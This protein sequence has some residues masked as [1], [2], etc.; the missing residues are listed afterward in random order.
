MGKEF[1]HNEANNVNSQIAIF[2][3]VVPTYNE[4]KYIGALLERLLNFK[5]DNF[6]IEIIV[7][8]NG[9]TDNTLSIIKNYPCSVYVLLQVTIAEMRNHGAK[10]AHGKW[11]GFIDADCM[12]IENWAILAK[13]KLENN[14]EI[15]IVGSF[16]SK[17]SDA[18]WV[19]RLWYSMRQATVGKVNFLP[20]GN[21]AVCRSE[22]IGLGGFPNDMITGEDYALCQKYIHNGYSVYNDSSF[23][24]IH[25]GN[26]KKL[27]EIY[28]KEIWYGL[29]FQKAFKENLLSKVFWATAVFSL[30]CLLIVTLPAFMFFSEVFVLKFLFLVGLVFVGGVVGFYALVATIR[31]GKISYFFGYN[32]IFFSYFLGRSAAI[33]KLLKLTRSN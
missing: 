12:P 10:M 25:Y 30:G 9:S 4:E 21:M 23:K 20:A 19:E 17:T 31:S 28:K 7:I 5:L 29:S 33:F 1:F 32:L 11:I 13:N 18:T 2:S 26:V 24:T 22:F 6:A 3:V 27:V 14:P 8:D 15:G 16:Y